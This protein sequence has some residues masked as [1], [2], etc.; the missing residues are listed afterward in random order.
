MQ[1]LVKPSLTRPSVCGVIISSRYKATGDN[2]QPYVPTEPADPAPEE[3]L[4]GTFGFELP[5]PIPPVQEKL[6][7]SLDEIKNTPPLDDTFRTWFGK[8]MVTLN[9][10]KDPAR[11]L[12]NFPRPKAI[13]YAEGTRLFFLPDSWF[14]ALYPKIG[15][16]GPYTLTLGL[17][18]FLLSKEL[19][20]WEEEMQIGLSMCIVLGVAMQKFGPQVHKSL[21][22]ATDTYDWLW[23]RWRGDAIA[24]LNEYIDAIKKNQSSLDGQSILFEAKKENLALQTEAEYRRRLVA[25][26]NEVKRK[27]D[28]QVASDQARQRFEQNHMVNWI[29]KSVEDAVS[30][31]S[32]KEIL[33]KCI[34][35]LKALSVARKGAI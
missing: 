17:L 3:T 14:R 5:P 28:Y 24:R 21:Q 32:E 22:Q 35:D 11:D 8:S 16:T 34:G 20:V 2:S 6:V 29:L 13:K 15:V 23:Y 1:Q 9:D 30:R 33:T 10:D 18:S 27:L 19:I 4:T 7:D 25:V 12:V 31:Q 26:H